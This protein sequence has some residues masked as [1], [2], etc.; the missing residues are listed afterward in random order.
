L[1]NIT[2]HTMFKTL[3]CSAGNGVLVPGGG[4]SR[5][6]KRL[7]ILIVWLNIWNTARKTSR[8]K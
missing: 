6:I 5:L 2:E 3:Y 8:L 1:L 4:L 7:V